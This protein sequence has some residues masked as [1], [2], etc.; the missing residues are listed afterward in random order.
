MVSQHFDG[1]TFLWI[2]INGMQATRAIATQPAMIDD[3]FVKLEA[4]MRENKLENS[5]L[6]ILNC[7]ESGLQFDQGKVKIV[8]RKGNK[9]PKNLTAKQWQK[10]EMINK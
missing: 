2:N 6:H 9:N 3:W 8:C 1:I 7:D 10:S 5:P 4:V